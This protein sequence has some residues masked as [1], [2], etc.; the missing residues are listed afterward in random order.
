M[1]LMDGLSSSSKPDREPKKK[2]KSS[3]RQKRQNQLEAGVQTLGGRRQRSSLYGVRLQTSLK[4]VVPQLH[5]A[6]F[7]PR[8][9]PL[10]SNTETTTIN[11]DKM[12]FL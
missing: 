12:T 4:H 7:P 5:N 3:Q 10:E 6:I 2:K 9:K 11:V 8:H 1:A